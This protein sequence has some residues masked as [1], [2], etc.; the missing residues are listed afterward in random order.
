MVFYYNNRKVTKTS[1]SEKATDTTT[2]GP[3]YHM[4]KSGFAAQLQGSVGRKLKITKRKLWPQRNFIWL[5][6]GERY[7]GLAFKFCPHLVF[8]VKLGPYLA[9]FQ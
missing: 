3:E 6:N 7:K 1:R 4:D 5:S 2:M 9:H 8:V